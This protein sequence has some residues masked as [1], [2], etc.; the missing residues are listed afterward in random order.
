M[1]TLG[2]IVARSS[3]RVPGQRK[4]RSQEALKPYSTVS[5]RPKLV[6]INQGG[7]SLLLPQAGSSRTNHLSVPDWKKSEH[8]GT[9]SP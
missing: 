3:L 7:L 9:A 1:D 8:R 2:A 6:F 4:V 5:E